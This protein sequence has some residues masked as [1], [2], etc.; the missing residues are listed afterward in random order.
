MRKLFALGLLVMPLSACFEND[1]Q[2]GLL[3]VGVGAALTHATGG[4]LMAGSILGGFAGT[5]CDDFNVCGP[6]Y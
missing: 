5:L 3:G 6:R 2:R 1:I 4:S